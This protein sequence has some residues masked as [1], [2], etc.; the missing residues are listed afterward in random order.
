MRITF[1]TRS[2]LVNAVGYGHQDRRRAGWAD[3]AGDRGAGQQDNAPMLIDHWPLLGLRLITSGLELR[4]PA[5][6]E[7]SDLADLA[8]RGIERIAAHGQVTTTRRLRLTRDRWEAADR[9]PVTIT[10]LTPCLPLFGLPADGREPRH[11]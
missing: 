10:G 3:N 11:P 1:R 5:G 6:E 4:L 8:A 7:L 9:E 2:S